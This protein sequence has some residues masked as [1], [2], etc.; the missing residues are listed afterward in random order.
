MRNV[1]RQVPASLPDRRVIDFQI[2]RLARALHGLGDAIGADVGRPIDVLRRL[3]A[4][5]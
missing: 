3:E 1:G 5:R 2:L 4:C